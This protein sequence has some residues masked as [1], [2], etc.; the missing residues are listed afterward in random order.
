[1]IKLTTNEL[2][3]RMGVEYGVA[4]SIIK[5]MQ[6]Y[7]KAKECGKI[8]TL[9]GKGKPSTIYEIEEEFSLSFKENV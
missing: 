7:G 2:A 3:K 6:K 5:L 1:M 4:A 9:S 8:P